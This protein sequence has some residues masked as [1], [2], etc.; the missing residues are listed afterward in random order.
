MR[1][2]EGDP[3]YGGW[4]QAKYQLGV[5]YYD[6]LGV[7]ADLVSQSLT[8]SVSAASSAL[9]P[10][11]EGSSACWRWPTLAGRR[12]ATSFPVLSTMLAVPILWCA[13]CCV[14]V[15]VCVCDT[16]TLQGFGVGQSDTEAERWW[17]LA[18]SH[19]NDPSSVRA[20]STLGMYYSRPETLDLKKVSHMV[21]PRL[22]WIHTPCRPFTGHRQRLRMVTRKPWVGGGGGGGL[23]MNCEL[24]VLLLSSCSRFAAPAW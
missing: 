23:V 14:C 10:R 1:S 8:Q 24:V 4:G 20:Q 15:C 13:M 7:K 17:A 16:V 18:G 21:R 2:A 22:P 11:V 9:S 3:P 19:G 12:T 6:G 5:M